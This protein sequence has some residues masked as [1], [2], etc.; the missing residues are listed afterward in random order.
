MRIRWRNVDGLDLRS[1]VGIPNGVSAELVYY[2]DTASQSTSSAS[3]TT[4]AC[5][6]AFKWTDDRFVR[7]LPVHAVEEVFLVTALRGRRLNSFVSRNL[8]D[9][10]G[11]STAR[12]FPQFVPPYARFAA[13]AGGPESS[14]TTPSHC[15]GRRSLRL[16][17]S[18]SS[19]PRS[20]GSSYRRTPQEARPRSP[21][22]T[23]PPIRRHLVREHLAL[24]VRNRLAINAENE[25]SRC[26]RP[27][28]ASARSSP[29]QL[30]AKASVTIELNSEL[31]ALSTGSRSIVER[32]ISV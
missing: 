12:K 21:P 5:I 10:Q 11:R 28:H 29:P 22:A 1:L 32:S 27:A 13:N 18:A 8:P 19:R 15:P 4:T 16:D 31:D 24:L 25:F 23:A 7:K 2:A 17:Q 6:A 3:E 14:H 26:G 9:L 20:R 30:P